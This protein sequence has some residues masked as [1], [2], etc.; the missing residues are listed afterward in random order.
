MLLPYIMVNKRLSNRCWH[1]P[2]V[3]TRGIITT[4]NEIEK[5]DGKSFSE[6]FC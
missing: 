2:I 6:I 3:A 1:I 5:T 4:G